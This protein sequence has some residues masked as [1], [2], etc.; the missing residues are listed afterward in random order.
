MPSGLHHHTLALAPSCNKSK[1]EAEEGQRSFMLTGFECFLLA[2]GG[3]K[4]VAVYGY[5]DMVFRHV[6]AYGTVWIQSPYCW[7]GSSFSLPGLCGGL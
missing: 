5:G 1:G 6:S 7:Y 3:E 2:D 4:N